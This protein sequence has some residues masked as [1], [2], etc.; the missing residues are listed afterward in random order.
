MIVPLLILCAVLVASV[1]IDAS[2]THLAQVLLGMALTQGAVLV[3]AAAELSN[4]KWIKTVKR[5]LLALA[6][7][8]FVFPLLV[9]LAPYPW[10][11]HETR[12]LRGDFFLA[13]NI[14]GLLLLA[15]VGNVFRKA[16]LEES[17]ASRK[18]A[19]GYILTFVA[20][21]TMVAVDWTMSFDY[22]WISTMFP[23][24]Y[25][26][27]SVYAGLAL[28][29]IICFV[30]ERDN[31]GSAGSTVY[32][33]ASLFFGFAL[34]WGGLFYAQYLTIWYGNIPEEVHYFTRR[35]ALPGG[36]MFFT[37]SVLLLF[38]VPF[39]TLL[40]HKARHSTQVFFFLVHMVLIGLLLH[41][42][43][44]VFPYIQLNIGFLVIQSM[45]MVGAVAFAL[46]RGL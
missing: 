41:R 34:F 5:P 23:V 32:D 20:I 4:A 30:H 37:L 12:W 26:I 6:P 36:K 7:L 28:V 15:V 2:G 24:L 38:A 35:F 18:W 3:V 16:S 10:L 25:M 21:K 13:R 39:I 43:F 40:I 31:P 19:V 1:H 11:A 45:A 9:R 42:V 27:E 17:V 22:P 29:G 46:R 33:G 14:A 8:M 44:H